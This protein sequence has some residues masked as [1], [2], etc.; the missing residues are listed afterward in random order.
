MQTRIIGPV[1]HS[2]SDRG[3]KKRGQELSHTKPEDGWGG[4][5][6][7]GKCPESCAVLT[8]RVDPARVKSSV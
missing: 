4:G 5:G 8:A 7:E 2:S 6:E 1:S 3:G